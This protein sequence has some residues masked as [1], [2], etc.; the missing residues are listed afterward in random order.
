MCCNRLGSACRHGGQDCRKCYIAVF[1]VLLQTV[2][3]RRAGTARIHH[4]AHAH[5]V[6]YLK[7]LG[8]VAD[9]G[10]ASD[11]FVSDH[12]RISVWVKPQSLRSVC[13]SLWHTPQYMMSI[14]TSSARSSRR[15]KLCGASGMI[16][17]NAT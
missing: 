13:K 16:G 9:F 10:N 12:N 17:L 3:T 11:D 7:F 8:V 14:S 5:Q 1:A 15:S 6:A 4:T 2:R